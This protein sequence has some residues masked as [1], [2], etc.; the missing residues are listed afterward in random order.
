[1]RNSERTIRTIIIN[2]YDQIV[3]HF[4]YKVTKHIH[5]HIYSFKKKLQ[6][7]FTEMRNQTV[8]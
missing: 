4:N 3:E 7:I 1:M 2:Y 6:L 5:S 8:M